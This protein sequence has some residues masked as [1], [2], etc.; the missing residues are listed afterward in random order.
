VCIINENNPV[1]NYI[2]ERGMSRADFEEVFITRDVKTWG[3]TVGRQ[4]VT[5]AIKVYTRADQCGAAQVWAA[6]LGNYTQDD[7]T[8]NA[9]AAVDSDPGLV[10]IVSRD[11][12]GIGYGNLNFVYDTISEKPVSGVVP[13]PI[14]INGNGM[15][16]GNEN[17]YG[18][19]GGVVDAVKNDIYPSPP[20]RD[21][22]LVTKERF[23]GKA[24][25]FV[26]W[27]LT[28]GQRYISDGGYI[29][30]SEQTIQRELHFMEQGYRD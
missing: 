6:F 18:T 14:D 3:A 19:R 9:D 11:A 15:V 7:L 17:F 30:L 5:D 13:V 26:Y 4:D 12:F 25:D 23:T 20:A 27:I 1:A 24:K 16:D 28:E 22:Y 8:N 10:S 21:L 2:V 29:T